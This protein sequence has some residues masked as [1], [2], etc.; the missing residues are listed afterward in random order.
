MKESIR[1][2]STMNSLRIGRPDTRKY[3]PRT[4]GT[5]DP[6]GS[7]TLSNFDKRKNMNPITSYQELRRPYFSTRVLEQDRMQSIIQSRSRGICPEGMYGDSIDSSDRHSNDRDELDSRTS[8]LSRSHY[9]S[10]DA[11]DRESRKRPSSS[12]ISNSYGGNIITAVRVRPLFASERRAGCQRIIEMSPG[13]GEDNCAPNSF[14]RILNP[15]VLPN[16][17][18]SLANTKSNMKL[19]DCLKSYQSKVAASESSAMNYMHE[20]HFDYHFWSFDHG[21]GQKD[22]TQEFIYDTV[23]SYMVKSAFEGFNCSIFAYGQTSAGKTYTMMGDDRPT[24]MAD[25]TSLSSKS[26]LIPR[27]CFGMFEFGNSQTGV[28]LSTFHVS[29]IEIYHEHVYDL[30][31]TEGILK[32]RD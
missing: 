6:S 20:F 10:R 31:K 9:L 22:A 3:Q 29:Y 1:I 2:P 17:S 15:V 32:V 23:G 18:Q 24:K 12:G 27:V 4:I 8:T 7:E 16:R 30:L 25:S 14:I 13:S 21:Q 19:D 26:G 5:P 28:K 11:H